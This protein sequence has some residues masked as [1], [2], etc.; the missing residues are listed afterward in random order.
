VIR[1]AT[2]DDG[3]LL[4]DLERAAGAAFRD[5]GMPEIADDEPMSVDQLAAYAAA[6]RSWVA[7]VDGAVA[8]YVLV[9]VVDG[10]AHVEQVSVHPDRQGTGVG[11]ALLD[12]VRAWAGARGMRAVTLTT[13]RD[14]PWNAPLYRHLGFV[15]LDDDQLG[16]ELR[17]VVAAEAAHGLDPATRTCMRTD[18]S[19][20]RK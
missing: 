8:G 18:T 13:F 12:H 6:G 10:D 7:E 11:R 17:A 20:N 15:D 2:G 16:P 1:A 14:V 5:I 3:E 4:R 19:V 9:D